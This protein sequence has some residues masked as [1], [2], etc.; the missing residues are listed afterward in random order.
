MNYWSQIILCEFFQSRLPATHVQMRSVTNVCVWHDSCM[1]VTWLI[2][3]VR[4]IPVM[5]TTRLYV[6]HDSFMCD[7]NRNVRGTNHSYVWH[8]W[9][10]CVP[11]LDT[12]CVTR[13]NTERHSLC[14]W[15]DSIIHITRIMQMCAVTQYV[16][17]TMPSYMRH[18]SHIYN[19]TLVMCVTWLI[20]ITWLLHMCAVTQCITYT[21]P[22]YV[23]HTSH[24]YNETTAERVIHPMLYVWHDTFVCVPWLTLSVCQIMSGMTHLYACSDSICM[25]ARLLNSIFFSCNIS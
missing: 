8:E 18:T 21:M 2:L 15:N 23:R 7:T 17:F 22:L 5:S 19:E 14:V 9:F 10:I 25:C 16:T 3:H 13:M 4:H 12:S 24:I 1:C 6:R 20:H 11:W